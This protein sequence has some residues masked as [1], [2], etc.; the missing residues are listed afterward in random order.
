KGHGTI[1]I[2]TLAAG[3]LDTVTNFRDDVRPIDQTNN[4]RFTA[5]RAPVGAGDVSIDG[6][7]NLIDV[8]R[9]ENV[10][11]Y[12]PSQDA[13]QEFKVQTGHC[14]PS[15]GAPVAASLTWCSSQARTSFA[16]RCM[17]TCG[18]PRSTPIYSSTT[19]SAKSCRFTRSTSSAAA[20]ACR[21][22]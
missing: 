1:P 5:N 21:S 18:I 17:S 3:V 19:S 15:T 6:V 22:T 8:G 4:F 7:S 14:P 10:N 11:G 2:A 13:I 12:M 16:A 20:W 9:G